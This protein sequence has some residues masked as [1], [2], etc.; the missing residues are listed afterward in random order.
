MCLFFGF[1]IYRRDVSVYFQIHQLYTILYNFETNEI[2][3]PKTHHGTGQGLRNRQHRCRNYKS[4]WVFL[5]SLDVPIE[6][7]NYT[8]QNVMFE[9]HFILS[10]IYAT[11]RS[12]LRYSFQIIKEN[13]K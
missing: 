3:I 6:I 9:P 7:T 8:L 4:I 5:K 11:V 1:F 2:T 10:D 12:S 13:S